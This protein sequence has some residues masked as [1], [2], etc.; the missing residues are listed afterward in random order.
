MVLP[1]PTGSDNTNMNKNKNGYNQEV[2]W[3]RYIHTIS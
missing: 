3:L 2:T 1:T